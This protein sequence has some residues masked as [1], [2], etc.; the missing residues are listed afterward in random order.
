MWLP[1][2]V[3]RRPVLAGTIA[4]LVAV[5]VTTP[6][7]IAGWW[8]FWSA[9]PFAQAM[10]RRGFGWAVIGPLYGWFALAL[11]VVCIA[12]LGVLIGSTIQA[13]AVRRAINESER[14]PGGALQPA[15]NLTLFVVFE[16]Q[17]LRIKVVNNGASDVFVAQLTWARLWH[18]RGVREV[19]LRWHGTDTEKR[20]IIGGQAQYLEVLQAPVGK[21]DTGRYFIDT[22]QVLTPWEAIPV[23]PEWFHMG[24]VTETMLMGVDITT[25][26]GAA[27]HFHLHVDMAITQGGRAKR[28]AT[29]SALD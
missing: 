22:F 19:M 16:D 17:N 8:E 28:T 5:F 18:V 1:S 24:M 13:D 26:A 2:W 10:V 11:I 9:E 15:V 12:M 25:V 3:H 29:L 20:E 7:A 23:V 27:R 14:V 4:V 21:D 6:I